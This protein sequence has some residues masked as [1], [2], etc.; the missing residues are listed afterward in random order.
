MSLLSY[1]GYRATITFDADDEIFVGRILGI[2]DF[3]S[4][5]A[6]N[7]AELKASFEEAVDDYVATCAKIGKSP[8]KSFSGNLMLRIDPSVH[9]AAATAAESSGKSLNQWSEEVLRDAASRAM[10]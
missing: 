9:A 1:K 4:F 3:V 2:R 10:T 8:E 5:H 7:V 6:D